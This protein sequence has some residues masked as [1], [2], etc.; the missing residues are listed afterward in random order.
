MSC[1]A[2]NRLCNIRSRVVS[3]KVEARPRPAKTVSYTS[4]SN[5]S[6]PGQRRR[7]LRGAGL[8]ESKA[9]SCRVSRR[10]G[11]P[12]AALRSGAEADLRGPQGRGRAVW[13]CGCQGAP[14]REPGK[15][16]EVRPAS[17]VPRSERPLP[18]ADT[19]CQ[20]AEVPGGL[21]AAASKVA[22]TQACRPCALPT[23]AAWQ[24][25]RRSPLF[26]FCRS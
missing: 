11:H 5:S 26:L 14:P 13:P 3:A 7:A 1:T 24:G 18:S 4:P 23:H 8:A 2:R 12:P 9:P 10:Q 20:H 6:R 19:P 15:E 21:A 16:T 17:H 25:S 22:Q